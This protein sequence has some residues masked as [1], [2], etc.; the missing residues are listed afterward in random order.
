MDVNAFTGNG[1]PQQRV[2]VKVQ[3]KQ[4]AE[5][6][7]TGAR[8]M[9]EIPV[10]PG[11]NTIVFSLPDAKSPAALGSSTDSRVLGMSVIRFCVTE[12]GRKCL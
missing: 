8:E 7:L 2:S 6:V 1:L 4:V 9:K 3:D 12:Q 11:L 5:W 10:A